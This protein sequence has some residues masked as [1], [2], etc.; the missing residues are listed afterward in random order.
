VLLGLLLLGFAA[1]AVWRLVESLQ[2]RD[3]EGDAPKG[4]AK[5]LGYAALAVWYATLAG[6]TGWIL[7]G[8]SS[9]PDASRR[10]ATEGMFGLPFGRALVGAVGLGLI[11]A[12]VGSVVFAYRR[13][14]LAKLHT[15]RMSPETRHVAD[16]AGRIGYASRAVVFALLGGFLVE[17]AWTYDPH[18]VR[19]VD[20]ALLR[21]AQAPL[22]PLLLTAVALGF[23]CYGVWSLMQ[24]RYRAV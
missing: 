5:R 20:G 8:H 1:H 18:D 9:N 23:L 7:L 14:H 6:L 16:L 10:Q 2:D 12:A 17:A 22:G 21:L 13:R 24:A 3:R 11:G 15:E 4:L 19:G